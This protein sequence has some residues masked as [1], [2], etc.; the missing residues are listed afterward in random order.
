MTLADLLVGFSVMSSE[1]VN[2]GEATLE[3][4][5]YS[6]SVVVELLV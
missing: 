5:V 3:V 6:F 2:S 4:D 1:Y